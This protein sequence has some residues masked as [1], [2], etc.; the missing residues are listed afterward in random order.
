MRS[1][2][3]AHV[4]VAYA[5]DPHFALRAVLPVAWQ[6]GTEVDELA[7][8]GVGG[9]DLSLGLR[10]APDR[11]GPLAVAVR[12]DLLLPTNTADA[13]LGERDPRLALGGVAEVDAGPVVAVGELG[14][15]GRSTVDTGIDFSL[16]TEL[17]GA[18]GVRVPVSSWLDAGLAVH[19]RTALL[20]FLEGGAVTS[21]EPVAS[22][23]VH[24]GDLTVYAGLGAGLGRGYGTS[25]WRVL[26]GVTWTLPGVEEP[27]EIE[28]EVD[29]LIADLPED[30]LSEDEPEPAGPT[31]EEGQVA[32]VR[33][34]RVEI[35]E[36]I[37]FALNTARILPE[38]AVVLERVADLLNREGRIAHLL[39]EGHASAE[40]SYAY[41]YDLSLRRALAV[42]QALVE[43]GVHPAR[44]STRA[45]GEVV[46]AG[47]ELEDDRRV[48]LRIIA[49]AAP[50]TDNPRPDYEVRLPWSG[51][52]VDVGW[53]EPPPAEAQPV[54]LLDDAEAP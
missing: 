42:T 37:Q 32:R 39:I 54:D 41:N 1:R 4:G 19:G 9:G 27:G 53:P 29:V 38:S 15:M 25:A 14:L 31:W 46:S 45:M 33:S 7:V 18:L 21:V 44:L 51:L 16:R 34:D 2:A 5:L 36:P 26:S 13:Y 20:D 12:G 35:R 49:W 50:G 17:V 30:D 47:G 10:W 11:R 6:G 23:Q 8:A 28:P 22:A 3:T 48:E 52:P 24:V 43:A 40:G